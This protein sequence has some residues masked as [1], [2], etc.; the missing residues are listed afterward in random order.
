[1]RL[2]CSNSVGAIKANVAQAVVIHARENAP[3]AGA[4][5]MDADK[6]RIADQ[7]WLTGV[8]CLVTAILSFSNMVH[9]HWQ[10]IYQRALSVA[11]RKVVLKNSIA[12]W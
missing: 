4:L 11:V 8:W 3:V 9:L 6:G 10:S 1:M 7:I 5:A 2:V 12:A